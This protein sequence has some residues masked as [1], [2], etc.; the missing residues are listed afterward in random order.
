[1]T[2]EEG[3]DAPCISME[4]ANCTPEQFRC[5]CIIPAIDAF[6]GRLLAL[7]DETSKEPLDGKEGKR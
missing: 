4:E 3:K 1:M 6:A 7:I 2:E 5:L